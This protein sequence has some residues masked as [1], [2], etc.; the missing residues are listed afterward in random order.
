M[1][2]EP[3]V[4][5]VMAS[6]NEPE[7]YIS[8]SIDSILN[9][10]YQNIELLIADDSTKEE[11]IKTIDKFA[12]SDSRIAVIRQS[13]RMG[14]VKARNECLTKAKGEYI[15]ILDADD[16]AEPERIEKQVSFLQSN[17]KVDLLGTGMTIID[18][19][20]KEVSYRYY[21]AKGLPLHFWMCFRNPLGHPTVMFRRKIVDDGFLYRKDFGNGEGGKVSW[22][23]E[24][25]DLWFRCRNAGYK[26]Y[27]LHELLIRYRIDGDMALTRKRDNNNNLRIR[28]KNFKLKYF[29]FDSISVM[30]ALMRNITPTKVVSSYYKHENR[31]S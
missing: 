11:T 16:I 12:S 30:F 18:G 5:V 22:G 27:N 26:L 31:K 14:V 28:V 21:P 20:G 15:A 23:G 25:L 4:S 10:S 6:F 3:L 17:E 13:E 19:D 8:M 9:Q 29:F 1:N 7:H 24:D 2:R